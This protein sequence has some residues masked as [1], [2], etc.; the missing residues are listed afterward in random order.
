MKCEIVILSTYISSLRK[1]NHGTERERERDRET[2]KEM[3]HGFE[4]W[5][6]TG[7]KENRLLIGKKLNGDEL[8]KKRM[9]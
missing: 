1:Y 3:G 9:N 2:G 8:E 7:T 6:D 5:G 4:C